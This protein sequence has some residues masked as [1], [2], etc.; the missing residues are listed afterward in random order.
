VNPFARQPDPK[1]QHR[2]LERSTSFVDAIS[3]VDS[4]STSP[5]KRKRPVVLDQGSEALPSDSSAANKSPAVKKPRS[6]K[7]A[8]A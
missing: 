8:A 7:D 4:P 5:S 2:K 6:K 3:A 1:T